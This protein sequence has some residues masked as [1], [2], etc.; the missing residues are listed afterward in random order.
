MS[1]NKLFLSFIFS[2]QFIVFSLQGQQADNKKPMYGEVPK[3]EEIKK[4]DEEFIKSV[5][6]QFGSREAAFTAYMKLGWKYFY[7]DSLVLAMKRFNQ[8]WLLDTEMP[9]P[10]FAF[11]ALI[12]MKGNKEEARR[13]YKAGMEKD[14]N[15]NRAED[16]FERIADCKEQLQDYEGAA[17][18]FRNVINLNPGNVLAYKKLGYYDSFMEKNDEALL[19]YTKA[20]EL[21]PKDEMTYNNRGYL[22]QKM[23]NYPKAIEDYSMAIK[24]KPEYISAYVNRGLSKVESKDLQ[25]AKNDFQKSCELD[26]NS[27]E[28]MRLLGLAK[29]NLNDIKGACIDL[30]IAKKLGDW[31]AQELIKQNCK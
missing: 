12:E 19:N 28:L 11:A 27:G 18:A 17:E 4:F 9:D 1:T 26:P 30:E 20:I 16:C 7:N 31:Q 15:K 13:F 2:F 5:T 10:Y 14:K 3:S 29:L 23:K 24:L 21:D 22:Y 8:A 6:K 25:G